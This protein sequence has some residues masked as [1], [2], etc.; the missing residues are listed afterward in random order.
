MRCVCVWPIWRCPISILSWSIS[1]VAACSRSS[2]Y[3]SL[4]Y[5]F[6]CIA[7]LKTCD[8]VIEGTVS[9][10]EQYAMHTETQ[11]CTALP[12]EGYYILYAS[13]Q[14][15]NGT[16]NTAAKVLGI[17]ANMWVA[18]SSLLQPG[19]IYMVSYKPAAG[20]GNENSDYCSLSTV[21]Y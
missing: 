15:I 2:L 6:L 1:L 18:R 10:G 16:L 12:Q 3:L 19:C 20:V 13:T 8:V 21:V 4:L 11:N 7:A 9:T 5:V 17:P 14:V